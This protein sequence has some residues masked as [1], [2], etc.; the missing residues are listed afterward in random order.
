MTPPELNF[1]VVGPIVWVAIGAMVV[2]VGEVLLSRATTFLGRRVTDSY[3]GSVLAV[4]SM[5]FLG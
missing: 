3:I 5:F 1:S 2:L 4:F